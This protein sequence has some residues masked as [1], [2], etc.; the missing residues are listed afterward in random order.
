MPRPKSLISTAIPR[1][2]CAGSDRSDKAA[3]GR[4]DAGIVEKRHAG[5]RAPA[6]DIA[7]L[8]QNH[9]GDKGQIQRAGGFQPDPMQMRQLVRGV[10]KAL[11]VAGDACGRDQEK[12]RV[13][14][15]GPTGRWIRAARRTSSTGCAP[16]A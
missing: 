8:G 10:R 13:K 11:G 5:L 1:P 3:K 12:P 16:T 4:L 6:K 7:H 2:G 14:S 15:P 9:L